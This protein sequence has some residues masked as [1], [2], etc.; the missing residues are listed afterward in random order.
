MSERK[1]RNSFAATVPP[2]IDYLKDILR[3]YP[4]GG[5]ILKELIQNADDAGASVVVFL[6]DERCYGSQSL[7]TEGLGKYQG[8]AL[9][10]FNNA[11]FTAEDWE[12]IK[13]TGRS[14]KRKDPNKVGRFGIGF[15]SV[16]HM[17]G[18]PQSIFITI[19]NQTMSMQ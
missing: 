17:T 9:Y 6:H 11:E 2:F 13:T 3:R 12:G 7:K 10:A 14:I 5:Q 15:N 19:K 16:Y 18:E 1:T 8:P 4:D